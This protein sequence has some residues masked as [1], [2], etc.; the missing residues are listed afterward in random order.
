MQHWTAK[1]SRSSSAKKRR[2]PTP[3]PKEDIKVIPRPHKG[4]TV[5]N[6]FGLELSIAVIKAC[7]NSFGGESFL[8]R[9]HPGSNIIIL[10][11]P[12]EQVPGRLREINQLKIRGRIHPFNAYVA[13]P[14]DVLRG[15]VHGLPPGTTQVDLMANLRIRTQGVKIERAR[16]LGSWMSAIITFTGDVLPRCVYFMGAEAI[17]YPY[18]PTVQVRKICRSTGHRT[19]VCPTPNANVCSKCGTCDPTQGHECALN[20]AI[21]EEATLQKRQTSRSSS[22]SR[23]RS[24]SKT[25]Q[26]RNINKPAEAP[27]KPNLKKTPSSSWETSSA[28]AG[29]EE[30]AAATTGLSTEDVQNN[31]PNKVSWASPVPPNVPVNDSP[32]YRKIL[33][34]NKRL[35]QEIKQLRNQ[36][37]AERKEYKLA[38]S[39]MESKL[40]NA[41]K[42]I[43]YP[44][45]VG[46]PTKGNKE[47]REHLADMKDSAETSEETIDENSFATQ[48]ESS[49][50]VKQVQAQVQA[51]RESIATLHKLLADFMAE[52][53]TFVV[54]ELKIQRQYVNDAVGGLQRAL[55]KR[56]LSAP[57]IDKPSK[58]GCDSMDKTMQHGQK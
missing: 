23:S 17:C 50:L 4:L 38:I 30:A 12:H 48:S 57:V 58:A 3:L 43:Q 49:E 53:K 35:T 19:D 41:I 47:A 37:A 24:T 44:G 34:E 7:R 56:R 28:H 36:M 20:C 5:K 55:N 9:V 14:E 25:P 33:E 45:S 8:L 15:I 10:S 42:K 6:I 46:N 52:M 11:T 16:M 13:D 51:N 39:S 2:G 32:Q 27:G 31:Q 22:R 1:S 18:K 26:Q 21:C 40:E 29:K 54:E